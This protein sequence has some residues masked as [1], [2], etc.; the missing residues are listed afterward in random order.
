[1]GSIGLRISLASFGAASAAN[2]QLAEEKIRGE[3]LKQQVEAEVITSCDRVQTAAEEVSAAREGLKVAERALEISQTR[4][5][6]GAGIELE[7][8]DS[9]VALTQARYDVVA[10][11]AGYDIAQVRLLQALGDVS[12]EALIK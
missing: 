10:A 5:H 3:R 8:L 6:A 7:V 11:I 9:D 12:A 4:F 1:V 2:A